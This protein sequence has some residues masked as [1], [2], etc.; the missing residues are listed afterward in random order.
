MV[1]MGGHE[2]IEDTA[3]LGRQGG[4]GAEDTLDEAADGG[5]VRAEAAAAREDGAAE[6]ALGQVVGEG[7]V[8]LV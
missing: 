1:D 6:A 4:H 7:Q 5:A 2:E 8:G 3:L